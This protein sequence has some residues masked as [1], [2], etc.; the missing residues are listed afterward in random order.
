MGDM[1]DMMIEQGIAQISDPDYDPELDCADWVAGGIA[2]TYKTTR[3][4]YCR[5]PRLNWVDKDGK[6]RL[7]RQDGEVHSCK[8]YRDAKQ[9]EREC[10]D[11]DPFNGDEGPDPAQLGEW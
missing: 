4:K 6:W 9:A 10:P 8:Q 5:T 2:Y 7:Y 3:C 1:A 11:P